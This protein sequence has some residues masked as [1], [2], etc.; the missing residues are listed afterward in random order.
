MA[1]WNSLFMIK[2]FFDSCSS[3]E[4]SLCSSSALCWRPS[5]SPSLIQS[6]TSDGR[7]TWHRA[8]PIG[9][10]CIHL[11]TW[12]RRDNSGVGSESVIVDW[13]PVDWLCKGCWQSYDRCQVIYWVRQIAS[14]V[15]WEVM[16][17]QADMVWWEPTRGSAS[18]RTR[19]IA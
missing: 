7:N 12:G 3:L 15:R 19:R 5:W 1:G 16:G 8:L 6:E 2:S 18:A 9:L 10:I 4:D 14:L 11:R 17:G 13:I